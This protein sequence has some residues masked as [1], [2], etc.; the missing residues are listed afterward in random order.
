M[1]RS[2]FVDAGIDFGV[3]RAPHW[4]RPTIVLPLCFVLGLMFGLVPLHGSKAISHIEV[5]TFFE[6]CC[7]NWSAGR[8]D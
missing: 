3:P 1:R 6:V 5:P 2:A 8:D 4:F 7:G